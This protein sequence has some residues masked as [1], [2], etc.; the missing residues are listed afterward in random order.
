MNAKGSK[1]NDSGKWLEGWDPNE[2]GKWDSKIAWRTL[3]VTTYAL[4]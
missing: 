2:E 1:T 4:T 3:W